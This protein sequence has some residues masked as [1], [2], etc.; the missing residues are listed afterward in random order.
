MFRSLEGSQQVH[1]VSI[2]GS[3]SHGSPKNFLPTA[4]SYSRLHCGLRYTSC[5][6]IQIFPYFVFCRN[7]GGTLCQF[8]SFN[9]DSVSKCWVLACAFGTQGLQVTGPCFLFIYF[10]VQ[11]YFPRKHNFLYK[12]V[13]PKLARFETF[14]NNFLNFHVVNISPLL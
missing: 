3:R 9:I 11:F 4:F 6:L 7:P 1:Q 10:F 8:H 12:G 2:L 5:T 13:P 14:S